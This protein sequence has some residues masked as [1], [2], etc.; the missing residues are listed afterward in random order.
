MPRKGRGYEEQAVKYLKSRGYK[1]LS[2]NYHCKSGEIDIVAFK[3]GTLV[4]VEV[5]GASNLD[6]GH[7]AERF[8]R[9]KLERILK[10][11]YKFMEEKGPRAPFRLDLIVVLQGRIEHFEN[12]WVD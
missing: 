3:E 2:R 10:C 12:L 1:I 7:P 8:N 5:K 11:A 4:F 6:F 9:T